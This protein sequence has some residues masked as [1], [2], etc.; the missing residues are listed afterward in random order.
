MNSFDTDGLYDLLPAW[1]RVRDQAGNGALRALMGVI[2]SQAQIIEDNLDQLYDDLFIE[3]CEPWVIPYIGDLIGFRPLR[4]LGPG[5]S[6][7]TRAEVANTI[8][9]RRRKG[10]LAVIEQL[11]FDVTGWPTIAVEYFTRLA[12][13]QY[14]RNHVRLGNTIVDVRSPMT[15][16][17]INGAFDL[18]PRTLDVRRISS[19]RGRYNIPNIGVF[20]WRLAIYG[21]G[22]TAQSTPSQLSRT[23]ARVKLAGQYSLDPFG[24]DVPLVNPPAST[25]LFALAQRRNA[26]FPLARYP[27]YA[28]LEAARTA[29][30]AGTPAAFDF[31][32]DPAVFTVYDANGAAIPAS[33]LAVCDLSNWTV[34]T[35]V[36]IRASVDPVLGRLV[37]AEPAPALTDDIRVTCAYGFSGP[38]GGG[39]YARALDDGE[40]LKADVVIGDFAAA[41]LS[42]AKNQI[43]E[44]ADSGLHAGN[45]TLSP[46]ANR[47]IIRAADFARPVIVG[48]L[49]IVAVPQAKIVLRGLGISGGITLSGAGPITLVLEH[50]TVRGPISW[51]IAGGGILTVDHSLCAALQI[52]EAVDVVVMDSAVD[53]GTES[54]SAISAGGGAECGV[55]TI[56]RSTVI[57]TV[58]AREVPLLENS[59]CDGVVTVMRRQN[60][61]VRYS[62]VAPG[63]LTPQRFACQP[64]TAVDAAIAK[65]LIADPGLSLAQRNALTADM[66]TRTV[67]QFTSRA[68]GAPGYLQLADGTVDAISFGAEDGDEMGIF[69]AL[70]GPRREEN[71][72][73]RIDEYI[74]IG[75]EFGV[76]H[77]T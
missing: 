54:V 29:I 45:V 53:A 31:F 63:S 42:M 36:G 9:Y 14:V 5:Q 74:R 64:D 25:D 6:G 57:G 48:D 67:P 11:G 77:S 73:F 22:A 3:T 75:L 38:Y 15:A 20:V 32:K 76:I 28:E 4:P 34:P 69:F 16:I 40:P 13:T 68:K 8:G 37:F 55:L 1:I 35:E 24:D 43:A 46:D 21:G 56:A 26:P 47:L 58:F 49:A 41:D 39:A 72:K 65:A 18:P 44:I 71:L 60:G 62:Y 12:T 27:L 10:T 23:A 30:A 51:P 66:Q 59:I 50:C 2:A 61:C 7:G 19:G 70:Y 52:N 33:N 17:D